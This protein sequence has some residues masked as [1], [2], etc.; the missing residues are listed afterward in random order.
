MTIISITFCVFDVGCGKTSENINLFD[1]WRIDFFRRFFTKSE[2]QR[3]LDIENT[4]QQFLQ[5]NIIGGKAIYEK[6]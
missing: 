1:G 4:K 2:Q 6:F 3:L 5:L